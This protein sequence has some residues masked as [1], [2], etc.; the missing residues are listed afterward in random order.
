M[1]PPL[2][3]AHTTSPGPRALHQLHWTSP[4]GQ[5]YQVGPGLRVPA[6][7]HQACQLQEPQD[8]LI[9]SR[10]CQTQKLL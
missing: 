4:C 10:T 3:Q 8:P 5:C 6:R 9:I 1:H 7:T 2:V